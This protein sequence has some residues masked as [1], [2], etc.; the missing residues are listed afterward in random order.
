MQMGYEPYAE[1]KEYAEK[2]LTNHESFLRDSLIRQQ[3]Q[4]GGYFSPGS[5]YFVQKDGC[6]EH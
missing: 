2:M 3:D 5:P 6:P 1:R 4:G